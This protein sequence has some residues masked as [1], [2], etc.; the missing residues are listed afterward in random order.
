MS[1]HAHCRRSEKIG[2]HWIYLLHWVLG[3]PEP[4]LLHPASDQTVCSAHN[5]NLN[6][7]TKIVQGQRLHKP[8]F[9][10]EFLPKFWVFLRISAKILPQKARNHDIRD[11]KS[12]KC[13]ICDKNICVIAALTDSQQKKRVN[14][15]QAW[16]KM[17]QEGQKMTLNGPKWPKMGQKWPKM[18]QKK[19]FRIS[20]KFCH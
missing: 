6:Y 12:A 19:R 3:R 17:T 10:S 18:A 15:F 4:N 5:L 11:K 8:I 14:H 16:P 1:S 9:S 20:V 13:N 2:V 7:D